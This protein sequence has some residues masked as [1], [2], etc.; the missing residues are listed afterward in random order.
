MPPESAEQSSWRALLTGRA[1]VAGL[2]F[3]G[4]C[5]SWNFY[6]TTV[7]LLQMITPAVG[8]PMAPVIA[9]EPS[10][11]AESYGLF[12]V[13]T[14]GRYEIEFQGSNDGQ[15]WTAYPL[16]LQAAGSAATSWHLCALSAAIRLEFVVRFTQ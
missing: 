6:A 5:L 12:A 1:A 8:L 10:R 14:R 9:L 3:A 11:I 15:N 2:A 13:M 7:G 16:S 4:V